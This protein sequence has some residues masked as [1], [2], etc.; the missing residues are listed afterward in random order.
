MATTLHHPTSGGGRDRGD[1]AKRIMLA[2]A[3]RTGLT[4]EARGP[5]Y[6]WTDAF[7]VCN[8]LGLWLSS[9][10]RFYLDLALRLVDRVHDTLGRHR[11]D[12]GRSGWLS[13][14]AGEAARAHPTLGG[15]R[16][17]KALPERRAGETFD[18]ALEWERDGQYFH[19]LSQWMRALDR[20]A[21]A[22]GHA[23]FNLWARELADVAFDRFCIAPGR[24][25]WKMSIDLSRPLVSAMGQHDPI[26]GLVTC[27][28]LR[29]TARELSALHDG[30]DLLVVAQGLTAMLQPDRWLTADPLG[31]GGLLV[32]ASRVT[33]LGDDAIMGTL[34][35]GLLEA[36][37]AGLS[38]G[39][40]VPFD[41]PES[42]RVAFREL[43]LAVGLKAI[44]LVPSA[45]KGTVP[46]LASLAPMLP[47]AKTIEAHWLSSERRATPAWTAHRGINDV[48]LATC[49]APEGFLIAPA[50]LQKSSRP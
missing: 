32:D 23:R 4:G 15:L 29:R 38:L 26:D 43:G 5:R 11:G 48:M 46:A 8:F 6:L 33:Q 41:V 10:E 12:D 37:L 14:L 36:A 16:I 18:A 17:G 47:L 40:P 35:P 3:V 19:Y 20:V 50:L 45:G 30:P 2:Y 42:E 34:F 31:I 7:A 24:M 9:G 21:R 28:E 49:L 1:A 13:G 39:D 27:M 22:T 25:A 44:A